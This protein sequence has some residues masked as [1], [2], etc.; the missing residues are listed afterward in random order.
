M[1]TSAVLIVPTAKRLFAITFGSGRSILKA[2]TTEERFGLKVTLNAVD[3]A[4]IRSV[5][6]LTVDSPTPHSQIQARSGVSIRQFGLNLD[7]DLLREVTGPP[8]D[9]K[10]HGLRL[11]G[12]GALHAT[13]PF[14]L[15]KLLALLRRY[16][17]ESKKTDYR[18]HFP[19]V[20]HIQEVKS[21]TLKEELD[22]QLQNRLQRRALDK[23]W[24]AVPEIINWDSFDAF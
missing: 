16:L 14:T 7:Q 20:D 2:E 10:A 17:A 8:L 9:T 5:E 4:K 24:L 11:T 3:P 1:G 15:K 19:W 6:R 21:T 13:G 12:K 23:M 18:K 22:T